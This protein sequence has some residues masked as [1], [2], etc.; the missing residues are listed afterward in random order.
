MIGEQMESGPV[1]GMGSQEAIMGMKR[2]HAGA[3]YLP[4]LLQ[5]LGGTDGEKIVI[6]V[7]LL[8][9]EGPRVVEFLIAE[10]AKLSTTPIHAHRL[11]SLAGKLGAV[12]GP[13]ENRCLR[14]LKRHSD[15]A[16]RLKAKE[17]WAALTYQ[18]PRRT[19]GVSVKRAQ[20]ALWRAKL[21]MALG[22]G[23]LMRRSA[24]GKSIVLA[25]PLHIP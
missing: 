6:A 20:A 4:A 8:C 12:R 16:V 14:L 24:N 13:A 5:W 1:M 7:T 3:G 10:A 18:K 22:R 23:P 9:H 21:N 19:G 17:V 15:P 25:S 2:T 11:L